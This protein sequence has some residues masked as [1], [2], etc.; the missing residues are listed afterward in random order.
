MSNKEPDPPPLIC[1]FIIYEKEDGPDGLT[2]YNPIGECGQP[3]GYAG[4]NGTPY[5]AAH[6]QEYQQTRIIGS[7]D[8]EE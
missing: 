5:C 7:Y 1:L 8:P 4:L 6:M 3:A 2:A